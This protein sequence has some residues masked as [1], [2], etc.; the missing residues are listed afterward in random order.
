[1]AASSFAA[2]DH[3]NPLPFA[4]LVSQLAKLPGINFAERF[5]IAPR[6]RLAFA[7]VTMTLSRVRMH[8]PVEERSNRRLLERPVN[9]ATAACLGTAYN[10]A[11]QF[12]NSITSA[13]WLV[14][15][16]CRII[17]A[18][19]RRFLPTIWPAC[20]STLL[21]KLSRQPC[22]H[23]TGPRRSCFND[24][25]ERAEKTIVTLPRTPSLARGPVNS[26]VYFHEQRDNK[27]STL[28]RVAASPSFDPDSNP[29]ELLVGIAAAP[30]RAYAPRTQPSL[31]LPAAIWEW[32]IQPRSIHAS[33]RGQGPG[34]SSKSPAI[35]MLSTCTP[36]NLANW[37]FAHIDPPEERRRRR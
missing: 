12:V 36:A 29:R 3:G 19:G 7:L 2:L 33:Q 34:S 25:C 15:G 20:P 32:N 28:Y 24:V 8:H 11:N 4:R 37:N 27:R 14:A 21:P 16:R 5:N 10:R 26:P 30:A 6:K 31:P 13:Q 1:M 9:A 23:R 35:P 18:R 17:G 22:K